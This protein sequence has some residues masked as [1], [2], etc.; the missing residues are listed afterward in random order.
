MNWITIIFLI[1]IS[2]FKDR[3]ISEIPIPQFGKEKEITFS[4]Q[5]HMSLFL[6][7]V[8]RKVYPNK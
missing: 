7:S 6:K 3:D 1:V 8:I 5:N 2:D 4:Q